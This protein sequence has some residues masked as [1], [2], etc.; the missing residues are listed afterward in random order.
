MAAIA[1]PNGTTSQIDRCKPSGNICA[2][3]VNCCV[4]CGE[5]SSAYM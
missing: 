1:A 4:R 5:A 2:I 3:Q